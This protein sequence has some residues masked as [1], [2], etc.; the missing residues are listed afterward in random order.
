MERPDNR[1]YRL[2]G[3]RATAGQKIAYDKLWTTYGVEPVGILDTQK[4]FPDL[5]K[6][7]LEIGTGMGEAT[8]EI[9]KNDPET[10]YLAIEVHMPG[11]G[12]L[13][14][15]AEK[16]KSTNLKIIREDAHIILRDNIADK[17]FDAIHLYFPD[18]W[19]K[20]RHWKRR[21]V[22]PE[23]LS[24]IYPKLKDGGYIHIATDWVEYANWI[25]NVFKVSQEFEGGV[26]DRPDFRPISKFEGQG[27][28]KGHVVTDFRYFKKLLN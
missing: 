12:A 28:R 13:M 7:I 3:S 14:N 25:Q 8:A 23:F 27:L 1:S 2:R 4:I 15:M 18:P 22:Q 11:I 10:G 17:S 21:I 24:L 6:I 16:N 20:T 9:V 26:I 5:K 19:P